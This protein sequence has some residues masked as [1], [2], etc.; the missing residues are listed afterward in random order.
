M[1]PTLP[2]NSNST[3]LRIQATKT[4][5]LAYWSITMLCDIIFIAGRIKRCPDNSNYISKNFRK[6]D[7]YP[8]TLT[9]D[10]AL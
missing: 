9:I 7:R 6:Q 10:N 2:D 3:I 4:D 5:I 8:S 1:L